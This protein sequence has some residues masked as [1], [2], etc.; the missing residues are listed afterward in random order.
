MVIATLLPNV[1][2]VCHKWYSIQLKLS[3]ATSFKVI[4]ISGAQRDFGMAQISITQSHDRIGARLITKSQSTLNFESSK[5]TNF[6]GGN[7]LLPILQ[8]C[9]LKIDRFY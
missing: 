9:P 4:M 5:D 7:I 6:L 2:H 3:N 1:V 8:I